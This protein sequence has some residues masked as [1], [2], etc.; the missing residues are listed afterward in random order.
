[1]ISPFKPSPQKTKFLEDIGPYQTPAGKTPIPV[2]FVEDAPEI[3]EFVRPAP[4]RP[5]DT[6]GL[7]QNEAE[8]ASTQAQQDE[9]APVNE[10][11]DED[12]GD[13]GRPRDNRD[14]PVSQAK[15]LRRSRLGA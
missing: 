2:T 5:P 1:M 3:K 11:M 13:E 9:E 6:S 15:A 7:V 14:V 8:K 4:S 10:R 12:P